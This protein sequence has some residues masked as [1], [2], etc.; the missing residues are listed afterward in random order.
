MRNSRVTKQLFV[1]SRSH[2]VDLISPLNGLI[3]RDKRMD[4]YSLFFPFA[5]RWKYFVFLSPS[6]MCFSLAICLNSISSS[7]TMFSNFLTQSNLVCF[8]T[9]DKTI[10]SLLASNSLIFW[11]RFFWY[12]IAH[13]HIKI[14]ALRHLF[15]SFNLHFLDL[16]ALIF[17]NRDGPIV[18]DFLF[19]V[20]F[21]GPA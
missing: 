16:Y 9:G 17:F 4:S 3:I 1:K 10:V 6:L 12:L 18:K 20:L 5:L 11:V 15:E 2:S 13:F 8:S 7:L 19:E 21:F 14:L